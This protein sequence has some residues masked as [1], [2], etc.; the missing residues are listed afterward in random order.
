M[1]A[2]TMNDSSPVSML[3][4]Q[5]KQVSLLEKKHITTQIKNKN[6]QHH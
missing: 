6:T 2:L 3:Q 4:Q 1:N 5:L